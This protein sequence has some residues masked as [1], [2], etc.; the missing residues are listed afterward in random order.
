MTHLHTTDATT[1]TGALPVDVETINATLATAHSMRRGRLSPD[2]VATLHLT[3]RGHLAVLLDAAREIADAL[4]TGSFD[5][6]R[7]EIHLQRLTALHVRP[8]AR[9]TGAAYSDV[10]QLVR[11]CDWLLVHLDRT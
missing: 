1:G 3:L 7:M 8:I 9:S 2:A 6:H 4:P 5:R 10:Q 11:G